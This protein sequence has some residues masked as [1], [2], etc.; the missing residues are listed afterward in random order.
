MTRLHALRRAHNMSLHE[1][2]RRTGISVRRLAEYEY[3]ER[4]LRWAEREA[5]AV[6]FDVRT[7]R[8]AGGL[9]I[10]PPEQEHPRL[11]PRHAY[12]LSALAASA[13]LAVSLRAALPTLP[14]STPIGGAGPAAA[15]ARAPEQPTP[16]TRQEP[17][18]ARADTS[19]A[20]STPAVTTMPAAPTTPPVPSPTTA[21]TAT[22]EPAQP[23]RCP[24]T[25]D[26]GRVVITQG[27]DI[28]T[29]APA[30]V[31]GAIDLAVDGDGDGYAEPGATRGAT[32]AAAHAGTVGVSLNSWP[33]GNHIWLDGAD[34]WRS[35]YA[36]LLTVYVKDGDRVAAGQPL[37]LIGN[38]GRAGGPH[39]EI[40][41]WKDG[42]NVDPTAMFN[43]GD[44]IME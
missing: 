24:V 4:P 11:H 40:Q 15:A 34:G 6:I 37:G 13:A 22:A 44:E 19:S 43:C 20:A 14:Y 10:A 16:T 30:A 36:H 26:R 17:T 42:G 38:T 5:I 8:L 29:H 2:A 27:Y 35:G 3:E 1:L 7:Q 25:V 31:N 23:H 39:L 41:V 18:A 33:A 28:G 32:I 12:A 9:S 21:P